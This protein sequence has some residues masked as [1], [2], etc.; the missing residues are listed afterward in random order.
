MNKKSTPQEE[1][2]EDAVEAG[3]QGD[4]FSWEGDDE[5][6]EKIQ[7]IVDALAE[8]ELPKHEEVR[9]EEGRRNRE[10]RRE[11]VRWLTDGALAVLAFLG[12]FV[13]Q[14]LV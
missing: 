1:E 7:T 2:W 14:I 8:A 6:D 12:I 4:L 10:E 3:E 9:R 5:A 13:A 11:Q